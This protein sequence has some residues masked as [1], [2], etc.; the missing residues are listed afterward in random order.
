MNNAS[1]K[2]GEAFYSP[3]PTAIATALVFVWLMLTDHSVIPKF[4]EMRSAASC[5]TST[6]S[7]SSPRRISISFQDT[8]P[9]PHPSALA[10]ASFAANLPASDSILS[11]LSSISGLVK[12]RLRNRSPCCAM[13]S[14]NRS[15][16]IKST[17]VTNF[18]SPPLRS[19]YSNC[20]PGWINEFLRHRL[21][22]VALHLLD[23]IRVATV[24]I[25]SQ[26]EPLDIQQCARHSAI[27]FER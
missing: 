12:M 24:I 5:K 17:P 27:R 9:I 22:F 14:R 21:Y 3:I 23:E 6:G 13:E 15:I 25:Q 18:N 7:P 16:S 20:Q 10:T 2:N 26:V 1:P 19:G 4:L 8:S 11:A